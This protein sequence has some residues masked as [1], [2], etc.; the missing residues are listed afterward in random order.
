MEGGVIRPDIPSF[1]PLKGSFNPFR[2][3]YAVG[4][5]EG[6]FADRAFVLVVLKREA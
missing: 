3:I 1:I 2:F 5:D 4:M 6:S